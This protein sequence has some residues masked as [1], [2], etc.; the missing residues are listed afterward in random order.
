MMTVNGHTRRLFNECVL[1]LRGYAR[2]YQV[3]NNIIIIIKY[4]LSFRRTAANAAERGRPI[5]ILKIS[6][7]ENWLLIYNIIIL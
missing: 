3:Q 7:L 2:W 4:I 6:T 1:E 5:S